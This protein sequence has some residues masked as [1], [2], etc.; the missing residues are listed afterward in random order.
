MT[1]GAGSLT[2]LVGK[3]GSG[4]STI[5]NLLTRFHAPISGSI[6]IDGRDIYD[7]DLIWLRN[8]ITLVQQQS[9]LFNE[10]LFRNIALGHRRHE[11]VTSTQAYEC[12]RLACLQDTIS[13]LPYGIDTKVGAGGKALSGGQIQRV[14][15]AR[16]RLRNT[17]ILVLDESTSALDSTTSKLV[18]ERIR[19]WRAGMTKIII[20]HDTEPIQKD[21]YVVLIEHGGVSRSG[22][23]DD[24]LR[25]EEP[26]TNVLNAK[27]SLSGLGPSSR[28][29]KKDHV[30]PAGLKWTKEDITRRASFEKRLDYMRSGSYLKSPTTMRNA[31]RMTS[32]MAGNTSA[33]RASMYAAFNT[34]DL[35][36][37]A[38]NRPERVPQVPKLPP[39]PST[40]EEDI[41]L[42]QVPALSSKTARIASLATNK[43]GALPSPRLLDNSRRSIRAKFGGGNYH[44]IDDDQDAMQFSLQ[45]IFATV[46]PTLDRRR[47]TWL[48]LGVLAC[49][50]RAALPSLLAYSLSKIFE[51]YYMVSDYESKALKWCFVVLTVAVLDGC[52]VFTGTYLLDIVARHWADR[53][54]TTAAH[55]ILQQRKAWFEE[56]ANSTVYLTSVLDRNAE[57][58]RGLVARH[59]TSVL[60][61]VIMLLVAVI[62]SFVLSWKL[63][64]VGVG[65]T[66]VI[67]GLVKA[68]SLTSGSWESK[69]NAA[70]DALGAVFAETF[71]D[72]RTVCSLTLEGYFH[73]KYASATVTLFAQGCRRAMYMGLL[74]GMCESSIHF[75]MAV[76][77]WYSV[78]LASSYELSAT[79][80]FTSMSLMFLT[81]TQAGLA[82]SLI[83]MIAIA[84]ESA[85]RVIR[86]A[87]LKVHKEVLGPP[88]PAAATA[89]LK[90]QPGG[91]ILTQRYAISFNNLTFHYPSRPHTP[92]LRNL[93]LHIPTGTI[94]AIVGPSGS[95]KSTLTA[96]LFNLYPTTDGS[97]TLLSRPLT[98]VPASELSTLVALGPQHPTLLPN[99]SVAENITYGISPNTRL[100]SPANIDL[101]AQQA[102]IRDFITSLPDGYDTVISDGANSGGAGGG[103]MGLS[104]G[105]RQRIAI[106]RALVRR[107]RVLVLDEATSGLDGDSAGEVR[108]G[109]RRVLRGQGTTW[110]HEANGK[111]KGKGKE[112]PERDTTIL[113]ITHDI[114]TMKWAD[115]V[116]MLEEGRVVEEG[117]FEELASISG[118]RFRAMMRLEG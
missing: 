46:L 75:F 74:F 24:V 26:Q 4:K 31:S 52:L 9:F 91:Q 13:A 36:A 51:T 42:Q 93:T 35:A 84:T 107:A 117:R 116:V 90:P 71:T 99:A 37:D 57:E 100:T 12:A 5:S 85:T 47:R 16:A 102:A 32:L 70:N 113:M 39:T 105:Q 30:R 89:L 76:L 3:S 2:F 87:Q 34:R 43:D 48:V 101:A 14:A 82:L 68:M 114:E 22:L 59:A 49:C 97:I 44:K 58:M 21:D 54:R 80:I 67:V 79:Q 118:G 29:A 25:S 94:T 98:S 10:T 111:G 38:K 11:Q 60:N 41:E 78:R 66:P 7:L 20:T 83:P 77:M 6:S 103:G 81:C 88:E 69:I 45:R 27:T 72:I 95:G 62:W 104:G 73:K 28:K 55:R 56:D 108:Q 1:F 63:T 96:L 112:N 8:N 23:R 50:C 19:A 53:L 40:M 115:R 106:A 110:G 17:P 109:L 64:L 33:A 86:L 15:L 65:A 61:V 92:I 18:M